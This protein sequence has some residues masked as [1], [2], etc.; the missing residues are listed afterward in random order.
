VF[1]SSKRIHILFCV[2]Q[3][4]VSSTSNNVFALMFKCLLES[5]GLGIEELGRKL[6]GM[7]CDGSSVFKLLNWYDLIIQRKDNPIIEWGSLFCP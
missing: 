5:S 4:S 3:I 6:V 1:Q 7:G 2:D